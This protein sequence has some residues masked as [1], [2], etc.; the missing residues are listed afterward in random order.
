M[1][2][3]GTIQRK[4]LKYRR[5]ERKRRILELQ[6]RKLRRKKSA[7]IWPEKQGDVENESDR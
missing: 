7:N 1:G 3:L 6:L 5:D 4:D 2:S